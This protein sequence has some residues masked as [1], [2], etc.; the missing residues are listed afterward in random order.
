MLADKLMQQPLE[1]GCLRAFRLD[2]NQPWQRIG[3]NPSAHRVQPNMPS[4]LNAILAL[5]DLCEFAPIA[6]VG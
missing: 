1:D 2:M 4:H 6:G 3:Q 5:S